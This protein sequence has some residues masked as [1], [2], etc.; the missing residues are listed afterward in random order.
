MVIDE[1]DAW[2]KF[3]N[4]DQV[5]SPAL[6]IYKDRVL[7]NIRAL[8]SQVPKIDLLRPHIKTNK[9]ISV[10]RLMMEEGIQKFK[11]ATIAEAE[12]LAKAGAKDVLLAYQPTAVKLARFIKLIQ[13]YKNT[14]FSCLV[15]NQETA[16]TISE[17]SNINEVV[18][19]VFIDLNVGMNRTGIAALE[20]MTLFKFLNK[21]NGVSF[22]G[23]HAYDGQIEDAVFT[24]R[25]EHC[26]REFSSVE[27]LRVE[28]EQAGFNFPLLVAGGTP[29][30]AIHTKRRN[31]EGSPG[32]FVFWD[33]GYQQLLSEQNFAFAAMLLTRVI[34]LPGRDLICID[35]GYKAIASEHSLQKRAYFPNNPDLVPYSQSEEHLVL[36]APIGHNYKIGD[37]I[38]VVPWHVCPT[39]AMY[40]EAHV[41]ENDL[42]QE[43]WTIDARGRQPNI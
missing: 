9:S 23:F 1:T 36:K 22:R 31:T 13:N 34:S 41:I 16:T 28:I 7:Q 11:C 2:Y 15:D 18:V 14:S 6:L 24:E 27:N 5:D 8:I 26:S 30:F 4:S 19:S 20:A 25:I 38:F 33:R 42:Y 43:K 17:I 40:N 21:L 29:T 32:T 39:V 37:E 3:K 10:C 12:V 35:L